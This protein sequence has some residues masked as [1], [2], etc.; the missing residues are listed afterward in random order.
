MG[1]TRTLCGP[2]LVGPH[3]AMLPSPNPKPLAGR[4][5]GM[6]W[7]QPACVAQIKPALQDLGFWE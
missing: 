4:K 3:A 5:V 1:S 2:D 6:G 7:H